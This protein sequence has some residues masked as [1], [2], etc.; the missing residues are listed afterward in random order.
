MSDAIGYSKV[1][2][3]RQTSNAYRVQGGTGGKSYISVM[4]CSSA[5]GV[6]LPP[7]VVYKAKRMFGDWCVGGPEGAGYSCTDRCVQ[8]R[9][10]SVIGCALH[11]FDSC[12]QLNDEN[13]VSVAGL[14]TS[15]SFNGSKRY[16]CIIHNICPGL[17]F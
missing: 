14:I 8:N 12:L 7:F 9:M 10:L 16:F 3:H 5:T 4:F 2:V 17:C 6:L 15:R 11:Y 13:S 1:I